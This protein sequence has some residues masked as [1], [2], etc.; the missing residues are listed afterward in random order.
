MTGASYVG[1]NWTTTN[2]HQNR[3]MCQRMAKQ[4]V[5]EDGV[6]NRRG[7][8]GGPSLITEYRLVAENVTSGSIL[9]EPGP[10]LLLTC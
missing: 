3:L 9:P 10:D 5:T 6:R 4:S 2:I 1:A 8:E 7:V